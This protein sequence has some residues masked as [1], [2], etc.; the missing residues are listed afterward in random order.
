MTSDDI[1]HDIKLEAD[2]SGLW[3][4][5]DLIERDLKNFCDDCEPLMEYIPLEHHGAPCLMP[6]CIC[7]PGERC[8]RAQEYDELCQLLD[9]VR[10]A[11]VRI[12]NE[13]EKNHVPYK[14]AV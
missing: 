9:E 1:R 14:T 4:W 12:E 13:E 8:K 3:Y 2:P 6:Q 10:A 7:D 11:R 5:E